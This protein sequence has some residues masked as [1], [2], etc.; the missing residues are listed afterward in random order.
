MKKKKGGFTMVELIVV[1]VII[2]V[3]AA[4]LVPVMLRYITKANKASAIAECREVVSAS[5][6]VAVDLY[7]KGSL[8]YR[9]LNDNKDTI[10]EEANAH[11]S[12]ATDIEYEEDDATI[13][14]FEY[15]TKKEILVVYDINHDP[16]IYIDEDGSASLTAINSFI[17][18][19]SDYIAQFKQNN[20]DANRLDRNDVISELLKNGGE[21]LPVSNSQKKGT[22]YQDKD[23]YWHP[24]YLG[25]YKNDTPV[26]LF[27]NTSSTNHGGWRSNLV[28]VN[29]KVY[30]SSKEDDNIASWGA[31]DQNTVIDYTTAA[32][33]LLAH[34]YEEV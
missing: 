21:L 6:R 4:L 10:L 7:A 23:L 5:Q 15:E 3:L 34:G 9:L 16:Q 8:T 30:Q 24:Y 29:G 17:K 26:V 19:A 27:A 18:K 1:I 32:E 25:G 20:P 33:W 12:F 31:A 2:L 28:Y 22:N 13:L 14:S 11:G